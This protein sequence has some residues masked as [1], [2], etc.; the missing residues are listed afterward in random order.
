VLQLD[1]EIARLHLLGFMAVWL[2]ACVGA[3]EV[4]PLPESEFIESLSDAWCSDTGPCCEAQGF[5]GTS[6]DCKQVTRQLWQM[7]AD[8][9]RAQRAV[10]DPLE[11]A[12]CI[13]ARRALV[14]AC[15]SV[16]LHEPGR[17]SGCAGVYRA[18]GPAHTEPCESDWECSDTELGQGRCNI[19]VGASDATAVCQAVQASV[20]RTGMLH[21]LDDQRTRAVC[22]S[23][24]YEGTD[25]RCHG[26]VP[27]RSAC[28]NQSGFAADV[29]E[30]GSVC[31]LFNTGKCVKALALGADCLD[32]TQCEGWTCER[33]RCVVPA[34][35]GPCERFADP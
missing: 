29:C 3:Q 18:Q 23:G 20:G 4:E 1:R 19:V 7:R 25:G 21:V 27:Y 13:A 32:H 6:S 24:L 30:E 34:D 26:P 11:A 10:Y 9:A 8:R 5:A 12:R 31:D 14:E 15:R 2:S 17:M 28:N 33:G 22:R 35:I 16:K